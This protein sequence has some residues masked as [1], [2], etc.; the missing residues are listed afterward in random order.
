[1]RP[2]RCDAHGGGEAGTFQNLSI[3]KRIPA[4]R[5]GYATVQVN[6]LVMWTPC[7][8][9]PVPA[10]GFYETLSACENQERTV[11]LFWGS[12]TTK[13]RPEAVSHRLCDQH[14]GVIGPGPQQ[15]AGKS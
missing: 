3:P 8:Q 11:T 2:E 10:F 12:G 1:M 5:I 14:R 7:S 13:T 9:P 4:P 6:S 15:P